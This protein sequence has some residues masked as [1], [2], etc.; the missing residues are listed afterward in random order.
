MIYALINNFE[1]LEITIQI[2]KDKNKQ[3]TIIGAREKKL[4]HASQS[5]KM[6]KVT[7]ILWEHKLIMTNI[8]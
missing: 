1:D 7:K 5:D 3:F 2:F 6:I 8:R 4:P